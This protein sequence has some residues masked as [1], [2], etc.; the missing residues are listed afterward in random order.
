MSDDMKGN[1]QLT[2]SA[3]ARADAPSLWG[4]LKDSSLLPQWVP[5]VHH[6]E[7]CDVNGESVGS[8]RQCRVELGGRAGTMVERCI[9][10]VPGRSISY[11]V[12]DES[13]GMRK[14]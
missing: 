3:V 12:D 1:K 7:R 8:V 13:F 10:I 2:R 14:M 4:I 5:A 11:L 9:G 6:V